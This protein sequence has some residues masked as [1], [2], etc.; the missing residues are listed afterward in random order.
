MIS[1]LGRLALW[2]TGDGGPEGWV[3]STF[4]VAEFDGELVGRTSVRHSLNTWLARWGGHIGYAG[5]PAYRRGRAAEI[6]VRGPSMSSPTLERPVL[7]GRTVAL[8]TPAED[9]AMTGLAGVSLKGSS[10]A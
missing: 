5:R 7:K 3:P 8:F 6:L 1:Y 10:P 2:Q 9:D 4:L